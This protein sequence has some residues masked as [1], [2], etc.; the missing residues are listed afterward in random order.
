MG[1]R[2]AGR[3]GGNSEHDRGYKRLFSHPTAVEELLKGFLGEEWVEEMDFTSLERVSN[4]FVSDDMRERHS[5]LVWRLRFKEEGRG[6]FYVYVLLE[7]QSTSYHF[8]AVRMLGYVSLLFEDIIRKEKLRARDRLPAVLPIVIYNG[9]RPWKAPTDLGD[10]YTP[11]PPSLRRLLPD[12]SYVLLDEGRLELDRPELAPNR[13]ATLFRI[14]TCQDPIEMTELVEHLDDVLPEE[15]DP[16]LRRTFTIWMSTVLRRTFPGVTIP[17][18]VDL[19][20][21]PMLEEN[22]RVW[23]RKARKEGEIKGIREVLLQLMTQRFG[24]LP[25]RVRRKVEEVSSVPELR[26]LTGRVLV[27]GSLEEMNLG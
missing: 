5:D 2:S 12:L 26:K 20:E 3:K 24:H 8:M 14:E 13:V 23:A 4:S 10:L 19:E 6:W 16:E 22:M 9:R 18:L 27:A 25:M 21:A 17:S 7:F 15:E 11:V 1:R